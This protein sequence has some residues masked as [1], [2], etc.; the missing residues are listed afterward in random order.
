MPDS[1]PAA[2]RLIRGYYLATPAFGVLDIVL[3]LDLRAAFLDGAGSRMLW[4]ALCTGLGLVA[5]RWPVSAPLIGVVE[6]SV[7]FFLLIAWIMLPIMLPTDDFG[8]W[9]GAWG[10]VPFLLIGTACIISFHSAKRALYAQ[11]SR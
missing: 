8:A 11:V 9:P 7:N 4:Y 1:A 3:G 6:S 10:V 2:T 5:W